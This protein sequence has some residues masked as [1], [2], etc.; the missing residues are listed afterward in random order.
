M[1]SYIDLTPES[2]RRRLGRGRLIQMWVMVYAI[3][4]GVFIIVG[5]TLSYHKQQAT[6]RVNAAYAK[7]RLNTEQKRQA[8]ALLVQIDRYGSIIDRQDRL[9]W[10]FRIDDLIGAV[11]AVAPESITLTSLAI[12]PRVAAGRGGTRHQS[13]ESTQY[14]VMYV[15]IS[16]MA[17]DDL[18]IASF[19]AGLQDHPIFSTIT[20][21]YVRKAS[22]G[23]VEAREFG[24]TCEVDL[25]KKH[26]VGEGPH[27]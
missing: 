9:N 5:V 19:V 22:W 20:V 4:I 24:I 7:V 26:L 23:E 13:V 6:Q 21:D 17:P 11:G 3:T 18:V 8:D 10:S 25:S 14:R 2:S 1:I 16:G 15:E 12:T 27:V